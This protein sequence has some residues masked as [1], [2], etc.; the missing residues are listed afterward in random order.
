MAGKTLILTN[1]KW[2]IQF[3]CV[4]D[5]ICCH[6]CHCLL[7]C[8]SGM[9]S[10]N[11]SQFELFF[12]CVFLFV[13]VYWWLNPEPLNCVTSMVPFKIIIYFETGSCQVEQHTW[14]FLPLL[15][16]VLG[17]LAHV[18]IPIF[19]F[20]LCNSSLCWIAFSV[21]AWYQYVFFAEI[22]VVCPS[23]K[24]G[25]YLIHTEFWESLCLLLFCVLSSFFFLFREFLLAILYVI[26]ADD[27]YS[28][29]P[30][31]LQCFW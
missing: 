23:S 9:Y 12:P 27:K 24:W 11:E 30:F 26:S 18:T 19:N 29:L 1:V 31:R 6:C 3:L 5:T 25:V 14:I 22:S 16:R 8:H 10:D 15:S 4:L 20:D 17:L 2:G 28:S 13:G 7:F 21:L